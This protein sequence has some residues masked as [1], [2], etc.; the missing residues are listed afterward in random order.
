M[1]SSIRCAAMRLEFAEDREQLDLGIL[2]SVQ[3]IVGR[4]LEEENHVWLKSLSAKLDVN[5]LS[6][7]VRRT[8]KLKQKKD[9][10]FAPFYIKSY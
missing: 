8:V 3:I 10:K 7:L 2:F 4:E 6:K 9:R 5:Q 1:A